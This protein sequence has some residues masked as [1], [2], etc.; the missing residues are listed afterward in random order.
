VSGDNDKLEF[1]P[2]LPLV[3]IFLYQVGFGLGY[4]PYSLYVPHTGELIN[5]REKERKTYFG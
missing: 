2:V 5:G 4:I 1:S 3:C